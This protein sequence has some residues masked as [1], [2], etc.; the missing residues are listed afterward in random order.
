MTDKVRRAGRFIR[1]WAL[2]IC[3]V[4]LL[5]AAAA[6]R[7]QLDMAAPEPYRSS[8]LIPI[9][10]ILVVV[11][12]VGLLVHLVRS[13]YLTARKRWRDLGFLAI[14]GVVGGICLIAAMQIDAP[15]LVHMT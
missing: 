9:E 12:C 7:L 6:H 1:R 14:D 13:I 10:F 3:G 2:S 11:V 8:P 5:I 15:T 4:V